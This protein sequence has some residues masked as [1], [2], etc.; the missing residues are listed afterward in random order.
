MRLYLLIFCIILI[1][2]YPYI[3]F[4]ILASKE[5]TMTI[6]ETISDNRKLELIIESIAYQISE[7]KED[8]ESEVYHDKY[9]KIIYQHQ[10]KL[11]KLM[12]RLCHDTQDYN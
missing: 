2:F 12:R 4:K 11:K 9:W 3:I 10:N 7:L 5:E 1:C 6:Q 8:Q